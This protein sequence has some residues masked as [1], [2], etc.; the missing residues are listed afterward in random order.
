M[1]YEFSQWARPTLERRTIDFVAGEPACRVVPKV[2]H[3]L[4]DISPFSTSVRLSWRSSGSGF[5]ASLARMPFELLSALV[6]AHSKA[7]SR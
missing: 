3:S 1:G 2:A 4:A 5:P 6:G 7:G